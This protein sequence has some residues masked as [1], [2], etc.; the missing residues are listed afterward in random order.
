M[1]ASIVTNHSEHSHLSTPERPRIGASEERLPVIPRWFTL[2]E[3]VVNARLL[4]GVTARPEE[5]APD[6]L[7]DPL[8][9]RP[10]TQSVNCLQPRGSLLAI[11]I[12][13]TRAAR[14]TK[15]PSNAKR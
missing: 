4:P 15:V 2:G 6:R 14:L 11:A 1:S 7:A 12:K 3:Y 8:D 13:I 5:T 9:V 10:W